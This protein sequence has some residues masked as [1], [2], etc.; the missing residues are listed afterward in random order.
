MP[1]TV[2][3]SCR[4]R[5]EDGAVR[6][7]NCDANLHRPGAFLQVFG[8]V[9]LAVAAIPLAMSQVTSAERDLIPLITGCALVVTGV[10]MILVGRTRS[11]SV[12]DP[13]VVQESGEAGRG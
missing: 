2:C 7:A 13:V 1:Y 6:C 5:V 11:K 9:V 12:A 10:V 3:A 4:A 8:C